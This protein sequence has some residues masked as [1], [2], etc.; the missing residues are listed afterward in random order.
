M[1]SEGCD[2]N[3]DEG[4]VDLGQCL[5]TDAK[6]IQIAR[7]EGLDEKIGCLHQPKQVLSAV[8]GAQVEG[9]GALVSVERPEIEAPVD[10]G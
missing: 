8:G 5:V 6:P 1:L 9:D 2:R 10:V 4:G 3:H 7:S